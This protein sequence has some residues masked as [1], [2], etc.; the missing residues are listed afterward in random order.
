M[1]GLNRNVEQLIGELLLLAAHHQGIL[2]LRIHWAALLNLIIPFI[3]MKGL[4]R[5]V[6]Q[7]IGE[8][9]LLAAHHQGILRLRI[10]WAAL[11]N[12]ISPLHLNEGTQQELVNVFVRSG[13]RN[14]NNS[15]TTNC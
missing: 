4:N 10:H 7:L 13:T 12:Q 6:E 5:N 9:L 1:K 14:R 11:L 8:L 2:T 15:R 3:L